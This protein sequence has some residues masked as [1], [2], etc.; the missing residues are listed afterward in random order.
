[1]KESAAEHTVPSSRSTAVRVEKVE[2][3][4]LFLYLAALLG[5][6]CCLMLGGEGE[7]VMLLSPVEAG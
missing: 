1:M 4:G 2:T 5:E 3:A 7:P 6:G